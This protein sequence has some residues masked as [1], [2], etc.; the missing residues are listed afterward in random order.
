MTSFG[1][2]L[3]LYFNSGFKF[4]DQNEPE[5]KNCLAKF[6]I[7]LSVL[8]KRH[9]HEH[10]LQLHLAPILSSAHK[11]RILEPSDVGH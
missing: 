1:E 7:N 11:E 8:Q 4:F 10:I 9:S 2:K 3:L 5:K 6:R